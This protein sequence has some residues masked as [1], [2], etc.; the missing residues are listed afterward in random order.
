M[1][2]LYEIYVRDGHVRKWKTTKDCPDTA[3][4]NHAIITRILFVQR[5][6][7]GIGGNQKEDVI[8]TCYSRRQMR[9]LQIGAHKQTTSV[10]VI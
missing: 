6:N 8:I 3:L 1:P 10:V 2:P 7:S 9:M 4:N 5:R